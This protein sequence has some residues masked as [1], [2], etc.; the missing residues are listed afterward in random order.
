MVDVYQQFAMNVV[1]SYLEHWKKNVSSHGVVK[2]IAWNVVVSDMLQH[3]DKIAT[4]TYC[5]T[6]CYEIDLDKGEYAWTDEMFEGLA[7]ETQSVNKQEEIPYI[8]AAEAREMF[9]V[10]HTADNLRRV[11]YRVIRDCAKTKKSVVIDA[12]EYPLEVRE[13]ICKEL[14]F[15]GFSAHLSNLNG[16][17][18]MGIAW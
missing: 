18:R 16:V 8:N 17:P 1:L 11:V 5:Y 15:K 2:R 7:E 10:L 12:I 3:C 13:L 9:D 14:E 6:T 4:I